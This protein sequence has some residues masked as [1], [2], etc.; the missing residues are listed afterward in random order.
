M[1]QRFTSLVAVLMIPVVALAE[2]EPK[3][4]TTPLPWVCLAKASDKDG[5]VQVQL[6][7][8]KMIAYQVSVMHETRDGRYVATRHTKY[9]AV[10]VN[11]FV[12]VDGKKVVVSRKDSKPVAPKDLLT[13]LRKEAKVLVF[14][15]GEVDSY[16]L[17]VVS[18]KVLI[19]TIP[20]DFTFPFR[21]SMED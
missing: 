2:S 7:I 14:T 21:S 9:K 13:L 6:S 10:V 19:L 1:I 12:I 5:R 20:A 15:E 4:P 16:Y 18:E 8:P 11:A 17:D 3:K